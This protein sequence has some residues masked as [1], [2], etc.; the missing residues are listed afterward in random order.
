MVGA[1]KHK[2]PFSVSLPLFGHLLVLFLSPL[3]IHGKQRF[4]AVI[5]VRFYMRVFILRRWAGGIV[6]AYE[7]CL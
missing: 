2:D 7:R 1:Y 5:I 4:R 3:K 6:I